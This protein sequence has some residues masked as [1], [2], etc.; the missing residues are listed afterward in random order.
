MLLVV[1]KNYIHIIYIMVNYIILLYNKY[2]CC[3]EYIN[4]YIVQGIF[5]SVDVNNPNFLELN[6][7]LYSVKIKKYKRPEIIVLGH[8]NK[9][10]ERAITLEEAAVS[11]LLYFI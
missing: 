2:S 1:L 8:S 10:N 9:P 11:I 3:L 4:I 6:D 7:Y 5:F